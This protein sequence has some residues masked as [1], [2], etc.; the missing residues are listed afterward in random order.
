[1][2]AILYHGVSIQRPPQKVKSCELPSKSRTDMPSM[3]MEM[4]IS[5]MAW[6]FDHFSL[7]EWIIRPAP[8]L[9]LKVDALKC[10]SSALEARR[11]EFQILNP[12]TNKTNMDFCMY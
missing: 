7:L 12:A 1:M 8:T 10:R 6:R 11:E 3:K 5:R 2:G 9:P 4:F